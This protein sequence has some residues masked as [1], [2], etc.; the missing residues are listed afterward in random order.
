MANDENLIEA[1]EPNLSL[2][3]ESAVPRSRS[4]LF[5]YLQ[6]FRAPNVFTA[7]ADVSMGYFVTAQSLRGSAEFVL[8]ITASCLLYTGGMVLNDVFD[9]EVDREERPQRP[10]PSGRISRTW[11]RGL[12]F[13]MLAVGIAVAWA[14][15]V[16][17]TTS[18]TRLWRPGLVSMVL[19][20]CIVLYDMGAKK[21]VF[22]PLVM[23][24]CRFLNILLGM[25]LYAAPAPGTWSLLDFDTSHFMIAGGIGIYIIGVTVFARSEATVSP[26]PGLILGV[27]IVAVGIAMLGAFPILHPDAFQYR[28]EPSSY[29][30][31]ALLVISIWI[32]RRCLAAVSN[33]EPRSV[34]IAIKFCLMSLIVLDATLCL[35]VCAVPYSLAIVALLVP[36]LFLGRWIYST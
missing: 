3:S 29:W 1:A 18:A 4:K 34:Q 21:T 12:G 24:S 11:A 30:P 33:P 15:G 26:R 9:F 16:V 25:S 17:S 13:A 2:P 27:V 7:I 36:M 5:A 14:V 8:L 20:G 19:A 31:L 23:G 6:L 32:F 35:L 28:I 22:G 10:L